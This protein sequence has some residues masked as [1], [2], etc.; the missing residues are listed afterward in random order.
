EKGVVVTT[1]QEARLMHHRELIAKVSGDSTLFARPFREN[2]TIKYPALAATLQRIA[3]N[4]CDAFY[5]GETAQKLANFIQ[6]KGGIVTVEDLARYEAKWR[7]PVTFSYRGLTVISMSPP[8]SGGITLAQI[9]KMIEPFALPE[10]G[11][12][13][14]KTIQVLTEAERRAYADRNYF[15]GDPDFVE[16]PVE[17]LLDTGYL[18]ERMSGFS[19]ERATPSAEVAHGHIEFEFTES[20]ETTH[21]SI[22]DPFGNAVSVTTTLNGAYG[23]KLY[24]DE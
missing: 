5:K 3:A 14:M 4:G 2:D 23:S 11:H 21:Y 18:R 8:S 6:S 13:A 10:F 12:N 20:S 24:C 19:F 7:T 16:I 1:N 17:R 9:M 15:L 22:V